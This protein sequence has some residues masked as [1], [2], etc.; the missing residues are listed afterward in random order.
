V[1]SALTT[2]QRATKSF[3]IRIDP[4]APLVISNQSDQLAPGTVGVL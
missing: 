2:G 3:S 1:A 4:P